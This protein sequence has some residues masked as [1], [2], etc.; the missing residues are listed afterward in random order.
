[1]KRQATEPGHQRHRGLTQSGPHAHTDRGRGARGDG[2]VRLGSDHD[3]R[4]VSRGR[5]GQRAGL[6]VVHGE[7][8]RGEVSAQVV[9]DHAARDLER[10]ARLE[11]GLQVGA[12]RVAH[13]GCAGERAAAVAGHVAEDESDAAAGERQ[14]V[15]EV[16]ARSGSI[17]RPV[18]DRRAQGADPVGHRRQQ[19]VLEQADLLEQ[20]AALACQAAR[21]HRGKQ[22][23]EAEQDRERGQ[24]GERGL[25]S[26]SGT[27]SAALWKGP[28][29]RSPMFC[30]SVFSPPVPGARVA[31]AVAV[32]L[33]PRREHRRR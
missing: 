11:P 9:V 24:R 8:D 18:G 5:V 23:A 7:K 6:G 16:S 28:I 20:F 25:Q 31:V 30:S 29:T 12:Q 21:A 17:G 4:R 22:V 14:H 27:R 10:D 15:I 13:E 32:A 3:R 1:M 26:Q 19:G 33:G 2:L